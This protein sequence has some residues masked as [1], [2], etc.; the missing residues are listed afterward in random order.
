MAKGNF[1]EYIVSD[2]PNKYPDDGEQGDYYYERVITETEEKIV[3]PTTEDLIVTPAEGKNLSK[4]TVQGDANFLEENI[5]SGVTI[6]GKTGIANIEGFIPVYNTIN[7]YKLGSRNSNTSGTTKATA[8][9]SV[10]NEYIPICG[11]YGENHKI[12]SNSSAPNFLTY[13]AVTSVTNFI[14]PDLIDVLYSN[15]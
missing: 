1:I 6:W 3:T 5:K 11:N 14:Y 12:T 7:S 2:N 15:S 13:P 10:P 9:I 4:V 8:S